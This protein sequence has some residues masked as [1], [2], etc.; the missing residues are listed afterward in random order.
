LDT[1]DEG[2]LGGTYGGN[3]LACAAA[4][5]VLDLFED[6][7]LLKRA[8]ELGKALHKRLCAWKESYPGIGDVRGLG[9]MQAMEFVKSRA[10]K[11]PDREA[12]GRLV[13]HGYE[14]G[15]VVL[16]A[17]TYGNVIR[18]LMPLVMEPEQLEEGLG[19]LETGLQSPAG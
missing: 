11:E 9:P 19:V 7:S 12:V 4:L 8:R 14:H 17:G 5:Q 18:F 1:V 10:S 16:P 3:P 6:G 2:G 15:V 13:R